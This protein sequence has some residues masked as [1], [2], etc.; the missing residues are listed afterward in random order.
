M[1]AVSDDL[2]NMSHPSFADIGNGVTLCYETFGDPSDPILLLINGLGGQLI[3]WRAELCQRFVA[4]GFHVVRFDNRDVGLSTFLSEPVDVAD[5]VQAVLNGDELEVPYLLSDMAT[6]AV[7][8][9]DHLGVHRAHVV[10][11]SLGGMIAQTM[12]IE[13]EHRVASLT[14]MMSRTGDMDVGLPT[15]E[16]LA[17]LMAPP[18]STRDEAIETSVKHSRLWGGSL[19]DEADVRAVA[20]AK[21]DRQNTLD[22]T[23]RQ[24]AALIASG[25]RSESLR[26][27]S[28]PT[29][30]IHGAEDTLIQPDGGQRTA[31]V[32]PDAR[33]LLVDG[34]GHDLPR[35]VWPQLVEAIA[36]HARGV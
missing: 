6:D 33:L 7:G 2:T 36:N 4:E 34:M 35:A 29:L 5:V 8:L 27:L 10:G 15:D 14:S 23:A 24:F 1:S 31:E 13:H 19:A 11:L 20:A 30:V 21:W 17:A 28:L 18:S 12:A 9:L 25:S 32:I 16:A 26:R 22:G 3:E